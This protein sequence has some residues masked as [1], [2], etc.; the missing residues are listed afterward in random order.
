MAGPA[1]DTQSPKER[2]LSQ[3]EK[4]EISNFFEVIAD[5]RT[6][7]RPGDLPKW[8]RSYQLLKDVSEEAVL[9][10]KGGVFFQIAFK[11]NRKVKKIIKKHEKV[12]SL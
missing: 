3:K 2:E 1:S 5:M 11:Q 9:R 6:Y 12:L 10:I 4:D 8:I 7:V